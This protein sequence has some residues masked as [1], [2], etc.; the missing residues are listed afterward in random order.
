MSTDAEKPLRVAAEKADE[1]L[2]VV[3]DS[4]SRV[5]AEAAGA[6]RELNEALKLATHGAVAGGYHETL[7]ETRHVATLIGEYLESPSSVDVA[8]LRSAAEFLGRRLEMFASM[9]DEALRDG[10]GGGNPAGREET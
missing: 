5:P 1:L 2:R 6:I 3:R 7:Q 4:D 8:R 9:Q 10:Q